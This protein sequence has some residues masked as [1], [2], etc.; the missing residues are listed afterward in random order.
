MI[1]ETV[2]ALRW[3]KKCRICQV[4]VHEPC[5]ACEF[6]GMCTDPD[7]DENIAEQIEMF[8]YAADQLEQLQVENEWLKAEE[9]HLFIE[10]GE[11]KQEILELKESCEI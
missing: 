2:K 11:L 7:S 5:G 8:G 10:I 1:D 3:L 4:E 9:L 6:H